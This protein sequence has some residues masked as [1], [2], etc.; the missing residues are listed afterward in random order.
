MKWNGCLVNKSNSKRFLQKI[1]VFRGISTEFA[2][3]FATTI[4]ADTISQRAQRSSAWV[5]VEV[6]QNVGS[7]LACG[8]YAVVVFFCYQEVRNKSAGNDVS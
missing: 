8:F 7:A 2:T 3:C 4:F 1:K 5:K 6:S